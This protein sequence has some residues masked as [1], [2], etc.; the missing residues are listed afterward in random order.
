MQAQEDAAAAKA[1]LQEL[2]AR[3]SALDTSSAA[4]KKQKAGL[5]QERDEALKRKTRLELDLKEMKDKKEAGRV[6][7]GSWFWEVGCSWVLGY[8]FWDLGV[9]LVLLGVH[10]LAISLSLC[11]GKS[12]IGCVAS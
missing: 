2:E 11:V 1:Q 9:Q 6:V 10:G 12:I 8:V 5:L 4:L 3:C 7:G